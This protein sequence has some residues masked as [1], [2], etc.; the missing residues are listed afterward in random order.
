M[1]RTRDS[2]LTRLAASDG[3]NGAISGERCALEA[4]IRLCALIRKRFEEAGL[5]PAALP[6]LRLGEEAASRLGEFDNAR[7]SRRR[8]SEAAA[9]DDGDAGETF[10]VKIAGI[11]RRLR[12]GARLDLAAASLAELFAWCLARSEAERR[13]D[14][15]PP[16]I[17]E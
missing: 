8:K 15:P 17:V 13:A 12:D 16:G 14:P 11:V 10:I 6:V 4:R 2:R 1:P 3:Q 7:K 9:E 5:D